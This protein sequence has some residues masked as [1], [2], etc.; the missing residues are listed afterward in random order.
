MFCISRSV[1]GVRL[2][3]TSTFLKSLTL[4]EIKFFLKKNLNYRIGWGRGV[5]TQL[6]DTSLAIDPTYVIQIETK[7]DD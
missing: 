5:N 1:N 3:V 6:I 2:L 7:N 4:A